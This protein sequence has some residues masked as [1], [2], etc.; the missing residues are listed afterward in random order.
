LLSELFACDKE[1]NEKDVLDQPIGQ[2][3]AIQIASQTLL[4]SIIIITIPTVLQFIILSIIP[5]YWKVIYRTG[6]IQNI[7]LS[8][9][10]YLL[11]LS[12]WVII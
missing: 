9:A 6:F 3:D 4:H 7:R 12:F 1:M 11:H 2:D 10:I 8:G 5:Q